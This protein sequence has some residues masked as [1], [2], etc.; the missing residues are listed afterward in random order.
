MTKLA[1]KSTEDA[2]QNIHENNE[3]VNSN[4][5]SH[6]VEIHDTRKKDNHGYFSSESQPEED[7]D[8]Y[9]DVEAPSPSSTPVRGMHC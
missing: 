8:C 4:R 1:L 6:S 9:A 5:D 7:S 2:N 3:D